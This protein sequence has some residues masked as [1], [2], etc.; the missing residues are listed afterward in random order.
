MQET[1]YRG[2]LRVVLVLVLVLCSLSAVRAQNPPPVWKSLGNQYIE[3]AVGTSGQIEIAP[4]KKLDLAGRWSVVTK[5]GDPETPGDDDREIIWL[6]SVAPAG[7]YGFWN[8]RINNTNYLIGDSTT[9]GWLITRTLDYRPRIPNPPDR[10]DGPFGSLITGTWRTN[11]ATNRPVEFTLKVSLVR[12]L[13]RFEITITNL[14]ASPLSVGLAMHGDVEVTESWNINYPFFSGIGYTKSDLEPERFVATLFGKN[15]AKIP[16]YFEIYDDL[17]A[18]ALVTRNVLAL[19]DATKPDYVA[20]GEFRDLSV[21]P[22]NCVWLPDRTSAAA[23]VPDPTKS[24][25]DFFW[26]LCWDQKPIKARASRKIVTYYG[27]AA[28][29]SR[30]MATSTKRD[31]VVLAVQG[32]RALK[33][34]STTMNPTTL[35]PATFTVKAYVNNMAVVSGPYDLN[36]VTARIYMPKGLRLAPGETPEKSIGSVPRNMEAAPVSWELEPTGEY[37]GELEYFVTAT[38]TRGSGTWAQTVTRKIMV[39]ADKQRVFDY[40]WQLVSVPFGFNDPSISHV[41]GLAPGTFGA[42]YWHPVNSPNAGNNYFNVTQVQPGQGFWMF[43]GD[44]KSYGGT[45]AL[46]LAADARILGASLG[47]QIDE[48]T[49]QVDYGWNMIGNPFV[50][51]VYWGQVL[52]YDQSLNETF[53]LDEA[54]SKGWLSKTLHAY[55]PI[56]GAYDYVRYN[57]QLVV[58]FQ[59]YWLYLYSRTPKTLIFRPAVFPAADVTADIGGF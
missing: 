11:I 5:Q 39:P 44:I 31:N 12:D 51:P 46:P 36:D 32:P 42:M 49:I 23:Y 35:D 30:W 25:D 50:Y 52:V 34:N 14:T 40:R 43:V 15:Y 10:V 48:Q 38:G 3:G 58:P 57:E 41:F 55:N 54:V 53:T 47:K 37:S 27:V 19:E 2:T 45:L 7:Y 22:P 13:V 21:L 18:P 20:I 26:V 4:D 24:M 28:A 6:G 33:Y 29:T 16:D 8:L 1:A 59:G 56:S 9:G 17:A